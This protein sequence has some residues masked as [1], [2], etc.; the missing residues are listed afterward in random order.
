MDYNTRQEPKGLYKTANPLWG[1]NSGGG[2]KYY[3]FNEEMICTIIAHVLTTVLQYISL[4][5][6]CKLFFCV[7]EIKKHALI[8]GF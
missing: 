2:S 6:K 5:L 8:D 4:F 1:N 7:Y 3:V